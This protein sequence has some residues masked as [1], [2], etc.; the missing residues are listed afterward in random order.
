[1]LHMPI[2]QR[3]PHLAATKSYSII[4]ESGSRWV[5]LRYHLSRLFNGLLS[6][7]WCSTLQTVKPVEK[8]FVSSKSSLVI[9]MKVNNW[10]HFTYLIL[11]WAP[12]MQKFCFLWEQADRPLLRTRLGIRGVVLCFHSLF[13][14]LD[15][16]LET[17]LPLGPH[18]RRTCS[19]G[20]VFC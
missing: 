6:D 3:R 14:Q 17:I 1:M 10:S 16:D 19:F 13:C 11:P 9:R 12:Y 20:R 7:S 8:S 5:E 4:R 15:S 2:F 18:E